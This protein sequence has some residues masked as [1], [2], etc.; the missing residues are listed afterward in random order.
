MVHTL[1]EANPQ[2][3]A[4]CET[5]MTLT[6]LPSGMRCFIFWALTLVTFTLAFAGRCIF[7][8]DLGG[9]QKKLYQNDPTLVA[10]NS[11]MAA[12]GTQPVHDSFIDAGGVAAV[13][14]LLRESN[15]AMTIGQTV[16]IH[17]QDG[18]SGPSAPKVADTGC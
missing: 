13:V 1:V 8:I 3:A 11:L 7:V 5:D 14:R 17:H 4:V 12:P 18:L 2:R 16:E 15:C 6:S 9:K 10:V